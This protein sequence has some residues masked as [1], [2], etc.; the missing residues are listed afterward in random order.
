MSATSGDSRGTPVPATPVPLLSLDA[1]AN[2]TDRSTQRSSLTPG[3]DASSTRSTPLVQKQARLRTARQR[4]LEQRR[5]GVV[6]TLV[7][8]TSLER[9]CTACRALQQWRRFA[10]AEA[11]QPHPLTLPSPA[12]MPAPTTPSASVP[13]P[14]SSFQGVSHERHAELMARL[15]VYGAALE[16]ATAAAPGAAVLTRGPSLL[17]ASAPS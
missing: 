3:S 9:A 2:Y 13:P 8:H 6:A 12:A 1:F 5:E 4:Q 14:D 17:S 15:Q 7:L 11:A 10:E 16:Q